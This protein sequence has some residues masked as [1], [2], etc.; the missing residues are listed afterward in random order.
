MN[1]VFL[2]LA[3][4]LD[5]NDLVSGRYDLSEI[6]KLNRNHLQGKVVFGV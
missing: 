3:I 5:E 6:Q 4:T 1:A 2:V